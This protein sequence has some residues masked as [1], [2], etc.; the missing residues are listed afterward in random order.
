MRGDAGSGPGALRRVHRALVLRALFQQA[1]I[2]RNALASQI[3]LS[4][5]GIGR[6]VR[7]LEAA[8]L[9]DEVSTS[10]S[11]RG[12]PA[13]GLRLNAEGGYVLGVVTRAY[14]REAHLVNL[15]GE[16]VAHRAL[17]LDDVTHGPSAVDCSCDAIEEL[18]RGFYNSQEYSERITP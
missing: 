6:I 14:A 7:E 11:G 13:A 16:S 3:G 17:E 1:G 4:A 2:D 10:A 5:M 8:G 9:I 12:R 18:I 15:Q